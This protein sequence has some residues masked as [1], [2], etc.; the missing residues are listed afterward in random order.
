[1]YLRPKGAI[2]SWKMLSAIHK[3]N[4]ILEVESEEDISPEPGDELQIQEHFSGRSVS[5]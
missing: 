1:M 5:A 4:E 3:I 2:E